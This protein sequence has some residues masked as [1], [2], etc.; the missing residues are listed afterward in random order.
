ID[1]AKDGKEGMKKASKGGY[2]LILLDIMMPNM[3][4]VEM[5]K[6]LRK[7]PP[8]EK[9]G[10]I[11]LLTNLAHTPIIDQAKELGATDYLIK[12]DLTP[13]TLLESIEKFM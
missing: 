8:L 12:F 7:N 5:L 4:G 3:N 10:P 11:V 13:D 9:N 1:M 6:A 2:N